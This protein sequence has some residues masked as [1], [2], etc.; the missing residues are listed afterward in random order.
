M[1]KLK[2]R[3]FW[4]ALGGAITVM[5]VAL[6]FKPENPEFAVAL[7]TVLFSLYIIAEAMIDIR[8]G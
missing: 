1:N 2:S 4:M 7:G 3:K 6:G 8:R 5:A